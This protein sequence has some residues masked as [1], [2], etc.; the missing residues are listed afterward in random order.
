MNIHEFRKEKDKIILLIHPSIV[1]WD[2]FE[3][4]IPLLEK[5]YHLLIPALPGH[6]F[7]TKSD[8]NSVE[9]IAS[10]LNDW[11]KVRGYSEI[12]IVY[13]CSMDGS[14]ALMTTLEQKFKIKHCIMD[15]G[16][17]PYELS[18]DDWKIW[19]INIA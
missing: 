14:I 9:K 6:D 16:I 17:T 19:R 8:F 7:E 18:Y 1:K 11:I 12:E 4:V 13:G 3:Q 10:E 5:D 2:Y 15:G